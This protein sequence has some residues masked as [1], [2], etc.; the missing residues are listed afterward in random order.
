[1]TR[2]MNMLHN[3]MA[4]CVFMVL[5]IALVPG[6]SSEPKRVSMP[7]SANANEEINLVATELKEAKQN[8]LDV[9]SPRNFDKAQDYY[10]KAREQREKNKDNSEVLK[11][12]GMARAYLN[13]A[14]E[15][16]ER[17]KSSAAGVL[18]AREDAIAA[19][20]PTLVPKA[21][22]KADHEFKEETYDAE[23]NRASIRASKRADLQRN[24][25]DLQVEAI[26]VAQ[27]APVANSIDLAKKHGA[28]RYAPKT[29]ASA[30][31]KYDLAANVI[32]TDRNNKAAID[33]AS[34]SARKEA[35]KLMN[36]TAIAKNRKASEDVALELNSRRM[37]SDQL[38]DQMNL[39]Q[40][41]QEKMLQD[42]QSA[43]AKMRSENEKILGQAEEIKSENAEL[44]KKNDFNEK[45]A[46]AQ[47]QFSPD[48]AEVYRQGDQL[49]IRLKNMQYQ[50]GRTELPS[51][52]YPVL[53]KVKDVIASLGAEKVKV[54]GHSDAS[55]S[56]KLNQKLS[57]GRAESVAK[58]LESEKVIGKNQVE[59]E[60]LGFEK[61]I[62][63][64]NTKQGRAQNRRV[65]IIV[66]PGQQSSETDSATE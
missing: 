4:I 50:S 5:T 55:G 34:M 63:P 49:L 31:A 16:S 59:A 24:Y 1:M 3:I 32:E 21:F 22:A 23:K 53:A 64:N 26:K 60:G 42:E 43:L 13:L 10:A 58:Y 15:H 7:A 9:L 45:F 47:K 27:L 6:C 28:R 18:R 48:E 38:R 20:A 36:V 40:T 44:Q 37:A 35:T 25:L 29:L 8:Q 2:G 11:S 46:A 12:V 61:P 17:A 19:N 14:S 56:K 39:K 52:A 41:E 54:E 33:E 62:A 51:S 30:E 65:D 57:Q 66:T